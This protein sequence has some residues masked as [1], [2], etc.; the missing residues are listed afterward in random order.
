MIFAKSIHAASSLIAGEKDGLR[1]RSALKE[2]LGFEW[3]L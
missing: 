1:G 2:L 3:P